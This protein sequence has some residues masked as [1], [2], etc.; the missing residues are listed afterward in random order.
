[1]EEWKCQFMGQVCPVTPMHGN[2][3]INYDSLE[4]LIEDQISKGTDAL[5]VCVRAKLHT[6]G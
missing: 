4:R 5:I 1:M 6:R 3:D 2:K